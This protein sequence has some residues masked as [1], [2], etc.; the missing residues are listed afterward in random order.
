M[1]ID[2]DQE[3][4]QA[5]ANS[6]G[7]RVLELAQVF[8]GSNSG[9]RLTPSRSAQIRQAI[10]IAILQ[11]RGCLRLRYSRASTQDTCT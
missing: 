6:F 8:D 4:S 3:R 2:L 9:Q 1:F 11:R 5:A 10:A 7:R